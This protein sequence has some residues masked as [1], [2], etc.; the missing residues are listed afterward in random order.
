MHLF[1][2]QQLWY[3]TNSSCFMCKGV[4]NTILRRNIVVTVPVEALVCVARFPVDFS[5]Y[6]VVWSRCNKSVLKGLESICVGSI[7]VN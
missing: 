7:T 1:L 4:E 5:F 6:C 3:F 2:V